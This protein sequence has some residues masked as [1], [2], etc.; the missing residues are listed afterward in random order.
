M[1]VCAH[2]NES[3][4]GIEIELG[5]TEDARERELR[6][7]RFKCE[8]EFAWTRGSDCARKIAKARQCIVARRECE[9]RES[10]VE[11]P[12]GGI[13]E[14]AAHACGDVPK[15]AG[16]GLAFEKRSGTVGDRQRGCELRERV[17]RNFRGGKTAT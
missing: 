17:N 7:V 4:H 6:N 10:A 16:N 3:R 13:G 8:V 1:R 14:I 11:A 2:A 15:H 12:V 9:P 5:L